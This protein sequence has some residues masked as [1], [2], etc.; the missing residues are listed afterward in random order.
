[1]SDEVEKH[2]LMVYSYNIRSICKKARGQ[3][4]NPY[5]KFNAC[6]VSFQISPLIVSL[7]T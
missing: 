5:F 4:L 1:M 7:Y 3:I 2:D 6:L